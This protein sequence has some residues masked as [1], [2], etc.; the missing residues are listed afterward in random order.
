MMN[1]VYFGLTGDGVV[2]SGPEPGAFWMPSWTPQ[3]WSTS[4]NAM[5]AAAL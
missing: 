5:N 1:G 2:R 3:N 4:R